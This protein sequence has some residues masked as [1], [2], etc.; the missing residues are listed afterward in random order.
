M[1][2]S[3][4]NLPEA[5]RTEKTDAVLAY[6]AGDI[7]PGNLIFVT[8]AQNIQALTGLSPSPGELVAVSFE[9]PKIL[10]VVGR[11]QVQGV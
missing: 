11:L 4:F 9:S 1:L 3:V 2:D 7:G 6:L 8:H 10:K 5:L